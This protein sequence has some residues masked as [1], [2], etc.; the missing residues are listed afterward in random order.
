MPQ[1]KR[2]RVLL[3]LSGESIADSSGNGIDHE[4]CR[5]IA[6]R[7]REVSSHGYELGIVLGGGNL[8]RGRLAKTLGFERV[9]A[10]K[11][12]MLATSINGLILCQT[13][14]SL[15]APAHVMSSFH[16]E[17][18]IPKYEAREAITHL[19]NNEIVI[20]VGGTGN[21]YFTTDTAAA[22][23]ACEIGADVLL[24]ATKVDG[25]YDAD[26]EKNTNATR[27]TALTYDECLEKNLQ[28]MDQTAFAL[29]KENN[30]PIRVFNLFQEGAILKALTNNESSTLVTGGTCQ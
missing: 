8:F 26:P 22:L 6:S 3:K 24:K 10:D 15:G 5:S 29:C 21:P 7:I 14:R 18:I 27:F 11:V 1:S 13:L 20:F 2:E 30:L 9:G 25:I 12:G 4:A 17:G 23:R 19:E 28:I 16:I